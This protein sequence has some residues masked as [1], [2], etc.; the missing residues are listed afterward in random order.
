[1]SLTV[2][3]AHGEAHGEA[4]TPRLQRYFPH[5][6]TRCS[7]SPQNSPLAE[8]ST[9]RGTVVEFARRR[10]CHLDWV[11]WRS[12]KGGGG[13]ASRR[14]S[15]SLEVPGEEMRSRGELRQRSGPMGIALPPPRLP[16]EPP[17]RARARGPESGPGERARYRLDIES[18]IIADSGISLRACGAL[19]QP[20][21]IT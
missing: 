15:S 8:S 14:C 19:G 1:M 5:E 2:R 6:E 21:F 11:G 10:V 12:S 13:G 7:G 4:L 9:L 18:E 3:E 20:E 16:R 17:A